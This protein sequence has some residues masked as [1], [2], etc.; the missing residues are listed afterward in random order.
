MSSYCTVYFDIPDLTQ[1]YN[2]MYFVE[3]WKKHEKLGF[4]EF[5][6]KAE[7]DMHLAHLKELGI[8]MSLAIDVAEDNKVSRTHIVISKEESET[9]MH[10]LEFYSNA[11]S[12]QEILHPE[13]NTKEEIAITREGISRIIQI[14]TSADYA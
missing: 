11:L 10:G 6:K 13:K 9:I 2:M 3:V 4:F 1:L 14:I 5:A 12:A 7:R 8:K